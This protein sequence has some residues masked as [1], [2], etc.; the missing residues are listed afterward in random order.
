MLTYLF[1]SI[2]VFLIILEIVTVMFKLT[3][4]SEEKARFQ[5]ISLLTGT[6]FTTKEAELISQ[7][8]TRR[9]L[10]EFLMILGF[11]GFL[12]GTSLLVNILQNPF[13]E[14][15]AI[16]MLLFLVICWALI[17]YGHLLHFI[18]EFVEKIVILLGYATTKSKTKM[19]KLITRAKGYGVFSIIIDENSH[20]DGV[21]IM[22]SN[23][24]PNNMIILNVDKGSEFIG[25]VKRDYILEKGDN[26]LL[27]GKVDQVIKTF[28]L[29]KKAAQKS[30]I[31]DFKGRS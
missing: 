4:L 6:G 21:A 1:V 11:L 2:I 30:K 18:D 24:K 3:G 16:L 23:L 12:T 25:F 10:A 26:I 14:R 17:R 19:Y 7:H 20:L 13:N 15:M 29:D 31:I 9:K 28:H 22:N 5:V 8:P 27:Y